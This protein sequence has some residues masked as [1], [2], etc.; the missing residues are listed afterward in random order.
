MAQKAHDVDFVAFVQR[1]QEL[2]FAV[3]ARW[4]QQQKAYQNTRL[5][6]KVLGP[7]AIVVVI[8]AGYFSMAPW[9]VT[10]AIALLVA[11]VLATLW[12]SNEARNTT[13]ANALAAAGVTS[14]RHSGFTGTSSSAPR[15]W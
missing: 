14:E 1:Q 2:R 3:E 7:V 13:L 15:R 9:L 10:T 5:L 6:L 8:F 4:H 12:R 11:L